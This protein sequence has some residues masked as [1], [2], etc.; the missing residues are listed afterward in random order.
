MVV[1]RLRSFPM[2][3]NSLLLAVL[4]LLAMLGLWLFLGADTPPRLVE[5]PTAREQVGTAA[6]VTGMSFS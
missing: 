2:N 5:S 6:G 4:A 3:R 1:A